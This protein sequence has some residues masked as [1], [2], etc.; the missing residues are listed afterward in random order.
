MGDEVDRLRLR[1]TFW[2][3]A[4]GVAAVLL[5]LLLTVLVFRDARNPANTVVAIIGPVSA[6]IG[7]L[8]GYVAGQT[9]G[10]AGREKAEQRALTAEQDRAQAQRQLG[11]VA[12]MAGH[13]ALAEAKSR[14]PEWFQ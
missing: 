12:G 14:F 2:V 10:A 3:A 5:A 4:I 8:A 13:D 9:A 11:V 6:L 7:T 1:L